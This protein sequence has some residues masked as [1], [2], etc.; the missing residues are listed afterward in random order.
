MA[1]AEAINNCESLEAAFRSLI[2]LRLF[3][4]HDRLASLTKRQ[5]IQAGL[6][7]KAGLKVTLYHHRSFP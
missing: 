2:M 4:V 5:S 6:K 3:T 7:I 1:S